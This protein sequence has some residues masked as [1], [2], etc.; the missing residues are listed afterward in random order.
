MGWWGFAKREQFAVQCL[1]ESAQLRTTELLPGARRL[2]FA[3]SHVSRQ[4]ATGF[5]PDA[6]LAQAM[7]LAVGIP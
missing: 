6:Q 7:L 3:L 5:R 2:A 4:P 1:L